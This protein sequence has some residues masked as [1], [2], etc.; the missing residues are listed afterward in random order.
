MKV[1]VLVGGV[2][3]ARFLLGVRALPDV[4]VTAVV[5]I[6]DDIWLHGLRICP[7]LDTCMY[8][9]GGGIDAERGWG[10][11]GETWTVKEELAAYGA[12]PDWFGLGDRDIATHLSAPGCCAP[13]TRSPTVTDGAVPPLAARRHAAA[14]LR[15]PRSRPTSSSTTRPTG[16]RRARRSTSRSGGC[17]TGPSCPRTGSSRSGPTRPSRR[18]RRARRSPGPTPCC[19]RRRTRWCRIGTILDVPGHARRAAR[20]AGAGRRA[21]ADR[22]RAPVRGMAD[23]CLTRSASRPPPR[24]SAGTTAPAPTAAC[25]T[26]GWCT[27]ATPPTCP[28]SRSARCRC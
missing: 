1:T 8:T 26:A 23:A 22:R 17:A 28:G 16:R 13:A 18:P 3:G 6:G 19:S 21:L 25:S 24:R 11:A 7:D 20:H 9:L 27:P 10:R 15:R 2:G 4:E 12:E 5:N 14:G